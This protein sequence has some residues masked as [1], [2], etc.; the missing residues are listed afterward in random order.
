M[1]VRWHCRGTI[2][3]EPSHAKMFGGDEATTACHGE[4]CA[5]VPACSDVGLD[6]R[7]ESFQTGGIDALTVGVGV[8][9]YSR[10]M[11]RK[12]C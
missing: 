7:I 1:V 12:R 3:G 10:S 4:S 9:Q 2:G 6:A 8:F 11:Q 5:G